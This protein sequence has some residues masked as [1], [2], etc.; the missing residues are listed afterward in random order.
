MRLTSHAHESERQSVSESAASREHENT[1]ALLLC[2]GSAAV[3]LRGW[4]FAFACDSKKSEENEVYERKSAQVN[5]I[6]E[7]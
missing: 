3:K 4:T 1:L 6:S 7:T 2:A 5:K